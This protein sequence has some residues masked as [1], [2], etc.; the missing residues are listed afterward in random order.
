MEN[1]E[2]EEFEIL[3]FDQPDF[4]FKPKEHHDWRQRGPY[5][6]CK[7]CDLEHAVYV[8]TGKLMVGLN[9]KGQP[10]FKKFKGL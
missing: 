7:S 10:L 8:G 3:N 9:D 1:N 4:S 5:L 2:A 6:V